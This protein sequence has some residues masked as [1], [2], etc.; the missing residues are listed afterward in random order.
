[1]TDTVPAKAASLNLVIEQGATFNPRLT[2]T[3]P[4]GDPQDLDG[5]SA[6]AHIRA[7]LKATEVLLELT[8]D[9]GRLV[10]T[11]AEGVIDFAVDAADT[12]ALTWTQAVY[13]LELV[14]GEGIVTR[15]LQGTVKVV[16]E[17]TRQTP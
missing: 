4:A 11:P 16:P 14:S 5:Y 7:T 9:N 8:T 6:R 17:V 15:L 2:L 1:M 3:D 10:L 13:D 12:A